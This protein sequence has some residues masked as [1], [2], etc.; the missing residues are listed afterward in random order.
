MY[1]SCYLCVNK[2]I[3]ESFNVSYTYLV[4]I[5]HVH[6]YSKRYDVPERHKAP[7]LEGYTTINQIY[8]TK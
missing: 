3:N 7:S 5:I 1:I 6:G 8:R 4:I 2:Y